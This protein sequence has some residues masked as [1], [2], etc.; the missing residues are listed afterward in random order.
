[1]RHH[2]ICNRCARNLIVVNMRFKKIYGLKKLDHSVKLN[3][4]FIHFDRL[5]ETKIKIMKAFLKNTY[6]NDVTENKQ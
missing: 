5:F 6:V 1:M 2:F 4:K 3:E